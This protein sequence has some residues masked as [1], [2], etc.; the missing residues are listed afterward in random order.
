MA[1]MRHTHVSL[2]SVHRFWRRFFKIFVIYKHDSHLSHVT[3]V[4]YANFRFPFPICSSKNIMIRLDTF[5]SKRVAS[6]PGNQYFGGMKVLL[7]NGMVHHRRG[8]AMQ[9]W[10]YV[11][12][13]CS[14]HRLYKITKHHTVI[15]IYPS[16]R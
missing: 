13:S 12:V 7:R 14:A 10:I 15:W 8:E 6:S 16:M 2:K 5:V 11:Q 9:H 1:P 4:I 3:W